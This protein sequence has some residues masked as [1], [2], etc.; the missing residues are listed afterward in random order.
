M[1]PVFIALAALAVCS[2]AAGAANI[3]AFSQSS[4]TNTV[5][6]TTNVGDTQ[7]T[8]A[9]NNATLSIGQFLGVNPVTAF[10]DLTAASVDAAQ[11][12]A[13]AVIQHYSGHF[14]VSSA[15][16]CGGTDFLSGTFTDAAFGALSGPG[17]VVNVNNPP[18]TLSLAS[19]VLP[20]TELLAP[21]SFGLTFTNVTP[22]LHIV[23]STI[24]G[25]TASFAGTASAEAAAVPEPASLAVLGLGLLGLAALR[26]RDG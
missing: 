5:T 15:I 20:A 6:A 10:F 12:V 21:N 24:A 3:I 9:I 18:D 11:S 25:F 4:G 19:D 23:G 2:A 8:I 22:T 14:C 17:L 16:N 1:K 7:T 13:S 26:R